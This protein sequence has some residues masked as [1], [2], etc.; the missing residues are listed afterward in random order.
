[1]ITDKMIHGFAVL[2]SVALDELHA[3]LHTMEHTASG[4]KL[5]WLER[6]DE[7][8][9][10]SIAFPTYPENDTGVFHILEH[11]VLC[12]S[13]HY[14]V[15]E[16]FVELLK[17]SL[18]TFLNAMTFPDKTLYPVCSRNRQD[19]LNLM[20]VYMDAVLHP[21]LHQKPE[22]LMQEGWHYE[23]AEDAPLPS[24]KGVVFNEMKG[25]FASPDSLLNNEL[26]RRLFPD[27]CYRFVSGGDPEH[28]PEL[29]Y[30]A[31]TETHRK[32]Y[33]PSNAYIFLDGQV[34]LDTMLKVL[35]E[36]YLCEYERRDPL[37]PLSLQPPVSGGFHEI[38]FGL[39]E[40]EPLDERA[41]LAWGCVFGTYE[42][43][44]KI[45]AMQILTDVL[46][47]DNYAPLTS[48]LIGSGLAKD[49]TMQVETGLK[50]AYVM[51]EAVDMDPEKKEDLTA[52]IREELTRLVR[53]GLDRNRIL[54]TIDQF[55]FQMRERDYGR[56]PKG[57]VFNMS[58]LESWLYGG[59]PGDR[60]QVGGLFRSLREKCC[61][62]YLEALIEEVLL[63]GTHRCEVLMSYAPRC[64]G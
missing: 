37:A 52:L 8:M 19:L 9:T 10:F 59:S 13:E 18:N 41:R 38:T 55:E 6:P 44:E 16:P 11:S 61:S 4:A 7:N 54:A 57:L 53:E 23:F 31:F 45:T 56:M 26:N 39:S 24:Y 3:T 12:G 63:N 29:T 42:D 28:I 14:P 35:D 64:M 1:M 60:L 25:V 33:H 43:R 21:S 32:F 22:I 50:Q 49:V 5:V 62:G 27:N 58:V 51:L 15:K 30:E 2:G 47:G 17:S 40:A 48:R 34:D 46:C 20:R 36:E